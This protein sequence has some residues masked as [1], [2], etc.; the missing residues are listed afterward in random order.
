[1]LYYNKFYGHNKK[2]EQ[3]RGNEMV[4]LVRV[5]VYA[6]ACAQAPVARPWVSLLVA[7]VFLM[8]LLYIWVPHRVWR[9]LWFRLCA[10]SSALAAALRNN[11]KRKNS[12]DYTNF[13]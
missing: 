11:R 13:V 4:L 10:F 1:M 2:Q 5:K 6:M 9:R 7:A 12:N 8:S 3:H